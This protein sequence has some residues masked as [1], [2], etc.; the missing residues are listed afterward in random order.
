MASNIKWFKRAYRALNSGQHHIWETLKVKLSEERIQFL[1]N[2]FLKIPEDTIEKKET[3]PSMVKSGAPKLKT[4]KTKPKAT[5][6]KATKP[7]ATKPKTN[8]NKRAKN[9]EKLPEQNN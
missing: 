9:N 1:E 3:D 6:P 8:K 7:K 5:K 2:T 4:T